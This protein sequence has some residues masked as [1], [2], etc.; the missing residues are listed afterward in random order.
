[1]KQFTRCL[2]LSLCCGAA[3]FCSDAMA[4]PN[5]CRPKEQ[6]AKIAARAEAVASKKVDRLMR[7][8]EKTIGKLDSK[9][10]QLQAKSDQCKALANGQ[11][12]K[13]SAC[14]PLAGFVDAIWANRSASSLTC[15]ANN[16]PFTGLIINTA[17]D[18]ATC[19]VTCLLD[20]DCIARCK[21]EIDAKMNRCKSQA[22]NACSQIA[23]LRTKSDGYLAQKA[24]F[25]S[26]CTGTAPAQCPNG[27]LRSLVIN[28]YGNDGNPATQ[29]A[30]TTGAK[31]DS[32][33][34]SAARAAADA[35]LAACQAG[36]NPTPTPTPHP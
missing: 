30:G 21:G 18:Y 22:M 11:A 9:S 8:V 35:S 5:P 29:T 23:K 13:L 34:K 26:V 24:S 12:Q 4:S 25:S 36:A 19:A 1:M 33:N 15:M 3:T 28:L 16:N 2:L 32:I 17:L 20:A 6:A 14:S 7:T 31:R 10:V 27:P